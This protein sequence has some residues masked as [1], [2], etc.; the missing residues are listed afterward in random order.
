MEIDTHENFTR[1]RNI[2]D[3]VLVYLLLF[4]SGSVV[5]M[6]ASEKYL[7]LLFLLVVGYW[8]KVSDR[9]IDAGFVLYVIA[10]ASFLLLIHLYTG[11]SLSIAT[12]IGSTMELVLAYLVLRLVGGNFINSYLKVV[13]FLASFSLFGFL[14]DSFYLFDE[15]IRLLPSVDPSGPRSGYEGF[16]Y[17]Y[18]GMGLSSERN[19]S[20][21]Y[22][23][24][25]YQ[26]FLN[27]ALFML[28]FAHTEIQ[29]AR[30][31]IYALI[32]V[33]ALLT[34]KSTTGA[35]IFA[36]LLFLVMIKSKLVST[37]A[38]IALVSVLVLVVAIFAA[39]FRYVIIE[40]IE[41]YAAIQD[42]TDS[43]DRRSFDMLVDI[44]IFKRH[45]FGVG[46]RQYFREFGAIGQISEG[47]VSS[48][49]LSSTIAIYGLPFALFLF[50]S[51]FAFFMKYFTGVLM[52]VVPY[53][54]LLL[55]LVGE[56]YYT[57]TPYSM[58]LIAAIYA[59]KKQ[60]SVSL[61]NAEHSR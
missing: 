52:R 26:V 55:F 50:G 32:L 46:H 19:A 3:A 8:L 34:T 48:N 42:I 10:F 18:R 58:A 47:A 38:K 44:E 56:G 29:S 35:I 41:H 12:V 24:G 4:T 21:F 31:W 43:T 1:A 9:K 39:Q 36:A 45:I 57:F 54:M 37:N 28:F 23:P 5:Y 40:K 49:G 61:Q 59:F 14:T 15:V 53:F 17:V 60:G 20:I 30:K 51:Y 6:G 25:A 33:A 7:T 13:V 22:E 11:G 16:L 27:A 2:R